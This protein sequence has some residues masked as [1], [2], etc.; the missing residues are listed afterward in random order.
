T[1]ERRS[2]TH[3]KTQGAVMTKILL[4]TTMFAGLL[5]AGAAQAADLPRPVYK[6]APPAYFTWTGCYIGGSVGGASARGRLTTSLD[7]CTHLGVPANLDAVGAA[8]TGSD[9]DTSFI[10]GGQVGCN[11]QT[12]AFVLGVEGDFSGLST[13]PTITRT[14]VLSTLDTFSITNS[15]K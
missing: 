9:R 14:G 2:K 4:G 13:R 1:I 11:Y 15:V 12:G 10:G 8:G 5:V 3:T 7:S 6:A